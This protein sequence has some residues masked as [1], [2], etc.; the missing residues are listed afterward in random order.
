M[1]V[2]FVIF[3]GLIQQIQM[4]TGQVGVFHKEVRDIFLGLT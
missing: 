2:Q 4:I 3:Y 1:K